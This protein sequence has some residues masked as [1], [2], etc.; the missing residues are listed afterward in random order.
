MYFDTK[1]YK[2]IL[3]EGEDTKPVLFIQGTTFSGLKAQRGAAI[4][5]MIPEIDLT[6]DGC[7]FQ[8]NEATIEGGAIYLNSG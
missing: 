2:G 8:G 6:I 3:I 4:Y 5:S 7:K 1:F